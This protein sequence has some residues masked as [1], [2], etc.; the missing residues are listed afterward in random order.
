MQ[1][2]QS[3]TKS[4][5]VIC[6]VNTAMFIAAFGVSLLSIYYPENMLLA[7][8]LITVF[9]GISGWINLYYYIKATKEDKLTEGL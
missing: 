9:A 1:I 4:I 3:K 2:A 7:S 5:L 8:F 6:L